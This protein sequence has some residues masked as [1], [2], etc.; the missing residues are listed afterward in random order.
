MGIFGAAHGWGGGQK[1]PLPKICQRYPKMM[2]PGTAIPY[3]NKIKKN[4]N[5][6][7]HSPSSANIS[8]F[9]PQIS[10]FSYLKKYKCR[11]HFD[12]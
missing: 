11:L 8:I 6:V 3:L 1:R 4:M 12:T 9:S 2:K 10:K 7:T 5:P